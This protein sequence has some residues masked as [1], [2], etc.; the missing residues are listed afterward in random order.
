M[1]SCIKAVLTVNITAFLKQL[2]KKSNSAWCLPTDLVQQS[3]LLPLKLS[4]CGYVVTLF[5][6]LLKGLDVF[7]DISQILT[8]LI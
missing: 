6:C 3:E 8:G 4:F 7:G 1:I 5:L 2:K